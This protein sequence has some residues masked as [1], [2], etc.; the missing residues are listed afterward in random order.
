MFGWIFAAHRLYSTAHLEEPVHTI[1]R[2]DRGGLKGMSL[3]K[4]RKYAPMEYCPSNVD[5]PLRHTLY[6]TIH[7]PPY[8]ATNPPSTVMVC[9]VTNEAASEQ[10]QTTASAISSGVPTRPIGS[11]VIMRALRSGSLKLLAVIGV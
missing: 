5:N 7:A 8:C 4:N 10:S 1:L 9:P 3:R 11:L 6:R 2:P